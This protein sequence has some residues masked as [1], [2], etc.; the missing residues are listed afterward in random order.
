M[1]LLAPP[2]R[3]PVDVALVDLAWKAYLRDAGPGDTGPLF[4]G[5]R[6]ADQVLLSE[7]PRAGAV[8]A[9]L[10][11]RDGPLREAAALMQRARGASGS[12]FGN[13]EIAMLADAG[14]VLRA[15]GVALNAAPPVDNLLEAIVTLRADWRFASSAPGHSAVFGGAWAVNLALA[16]LLT[17][18]PQPGIVTREALRVDLELE[19][20]TLLRSW[21]AAATGIYD[22]VRQV[23]ERLRA[24]APVLVSF[25]KNARAR[26]VIG[27][28]AA[29]ETMRRP[30]IKRGWGLSDAGTTLINRQLFDV[31]VARSDAPGEVAWALSLPASA[32]RHIAGTVV[33]NHSDAIAEFDEGM[34]FANSVLNGERQR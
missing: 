14:D 27:V 10:A 24:A 16:T 29:L 33:N 5:W 6:H 25:S 26:E 28:L 23:A 7:D 32:E 30:H 13:N 2:V 21:G 17:P 4:S 8:L 34:A 11:G 18:A 22:R 1:P 20:D 9:W 19:R 12:R 15:A 31:G 3:A